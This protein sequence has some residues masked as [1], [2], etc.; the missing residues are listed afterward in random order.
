MS[1][2]SLPAPVN[3]YAGEDELKSVN[4]NANGRPAANGGDDGEYRPPKKSDSLREGL[5]FPPKS[6]RGELSRS[7]AAG[8]R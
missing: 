4:A 5:I 1:N 8:R 3:K 2:I 6:I 7:T